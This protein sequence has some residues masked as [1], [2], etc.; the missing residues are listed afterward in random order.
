[1]DEV[2]VDALREEFERRLESDGWTSS[3]D[4]QISNDI[5]VIR[6]ESNRLVNTA[7]DRAYPQL[8]SEQRGLIV[9]YALGTLDYFIL[10]TRLNVLNRLI[11]KYV[12]SRTS[13]PAIQLEQQKLK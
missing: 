1:M 3:Y 13:Q 5:N 12:Y 7:I 2:D 6:L 4:M 10:T 11:D 9:E 8:G